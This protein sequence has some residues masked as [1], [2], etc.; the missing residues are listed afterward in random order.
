MCMASHNVTFY[1]YFDPV[2]VN[3]MLSFQS[4]R[5]SFKFTGNIFHSNIESEVK[6]TT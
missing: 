6:G 3:C 4:T 1:L 5:N 2:L